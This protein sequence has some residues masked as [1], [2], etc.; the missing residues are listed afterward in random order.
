MTPEFY[1]ITAAQLNALAE[2]A[3]AT[4]NPTWHLSCDWLIE[5]RNQLGAHHGRNRSR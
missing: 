2:A 1:I 3:I 4:A 5:F